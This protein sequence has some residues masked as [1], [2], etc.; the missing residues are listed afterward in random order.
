MSTFFEK[1][2]DLDILL[3]CDGYEREYFFAECSRLAY[4]GQKLA[5]KEFKKIGFTSYK[6]C[7]VEG[8]QCH[9]VKNRDY[10]VIAFR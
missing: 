10:I 1:I 5:S 2:N 8:A 3:H 6:F 4:K 9:I 7:D